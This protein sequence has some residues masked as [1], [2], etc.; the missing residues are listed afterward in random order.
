LLVTFST[1]RHADPV[2]LEQAKQLQRWLNT[3][4]GIFVLV[5]GVPGRRTSDAFRAVTGAFLPGDPKRT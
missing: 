5:D 4:A 3:H 1:R 2:K